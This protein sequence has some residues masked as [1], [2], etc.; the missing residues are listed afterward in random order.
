M[1]RE[2]TVITSDIRS[3]HRCGAM[4]EPDV[5]TKVNLMINKG[6]TLTINLDNQATCNHFQGQPI[7]GVVESMKHS[8]GNE[9]L[10]AQQQAVQ[11][12]EK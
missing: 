5:K 11:R 2:K 12:T 1:K 7:Y 10:K 8:T 9:M 3:I 6:K 4:F